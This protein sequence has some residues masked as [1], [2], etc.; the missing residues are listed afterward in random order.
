MSGGVQHTGNASFGAPIK[1][2]ANPDYRGTNSMVEAT[3]LPGA[4]HRAEPD[5]FSRI[6]R[7]AQSEIFTKLADVKS[8]T[9]WTA[10]RKQLLQRMWERGDK[11]S[12]IAA[13]LG[14]KVGAVSVA[15]ARFGLKPRRVVSGRPPQEPDEPAHTIER[16]AFTVSRL[17]EYC[18]EKE[19][20]AQTGH[21]CF[22]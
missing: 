18:N 16:V 22:E 4:P 13:A 9:Y 6:K 8:P 12:A 2:S 5:G 17:V 20:V 7:Q 15:R 11:A 10:R 21:E 3:A 19:L 1:I 14:C